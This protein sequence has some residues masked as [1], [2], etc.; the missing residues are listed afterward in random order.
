MDLTRDPNLLKT[1]QHLERL[2]K[3]YGRHVFMLNLVKSAKSLSEP[4]LH[5]REFA[6]G[7]HFSKVAKSLA[8]KFFQKKGLR[9]F[10]E[11]YDFFI[12]YTK[13]HERLLKDVQEYGKFFLKETDFCYYQM[14]KGFVRKQD[15]IA[16]INCIDCLDR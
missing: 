10:Y 1:E 9:I 14:D 8:Q 12:S 5:S 7:Q 6:I 3:S 13:D 16:R 11:W 15:G 2:F 4:T